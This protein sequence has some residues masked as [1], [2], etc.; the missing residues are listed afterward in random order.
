[1]NLD[2]L[3]FT[4]TVSIS[5]KKTDK[6]LFIKEMKTEVSLDE[7]QVFFNFKLHNFTFKNKI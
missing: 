6:T 4:T 1:M 3:N 5:T 2:N 7:F